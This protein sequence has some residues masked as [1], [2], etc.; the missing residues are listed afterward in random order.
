MSDGEGDDDDKRASKKRKA[1]RA[2]DRCNS[3]HQPCDNSLPKCSVCERAGTECTYDRPIRKRG[4]R[5]GY[6]SQN[7]ERLWSVVLKAR[8]EIEDLV[9]QL[10][11]DGTYGDT[12]VPNAKFI[13]NNDNQTELV[14][15]FNESRIGRFLQSGDSEDLQIPP[16]EQKFAIVPAE[17]LQAYENGQSSQRN[18]G[19]L[20]DPSR[21]SGP[22]GA[23]QNPGDIYYQSDDIGRRKIQVSARPAAETASI[24]SYSP[25]VSSQSA[26]RTETPSKYV[27]AE[28]NSWK[29]VDPSSYLDPPNSRRNVASSEPAAMSRND[30]RSTST[31]YTPATFDIGSMEISHWYAFDPIPTE[32]L[33]N[34]GFDGGESMAQDWF[35]L[36][37]NPDPVEKPT[38]SPTATTTSHGEDEEE[39]WRRLVMRG[40]FM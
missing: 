18:G 27:Q 14:N 6:T 26:T 38:V 8:P 36:C 21:A 9:L 23:P 24:S 22:H 31:G 30:S 29:E 16:P 2:C 1:T 10:L 34:L 35:E 33:L 32:T 13:K 37:E 3:Q 17:R 12:G 7:G 19:L 25:E 28:T 5:V 4:P 39:V 15:Y 11:R 40:R 20:T